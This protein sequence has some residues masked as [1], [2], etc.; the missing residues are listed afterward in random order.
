ME[1]LN[2]RI[3]LA[4]VWVCGTVVLFCVSC[5]T[6]RGRESATR[7]GDGGRLPG[8]VDSR[9]GRFFVWFGVGALAAWG[10]V[11]LM[12]GWS[13]MNSRWVWALFWHGHMW[14]GI[15]ERWVGV[16]SANLGREDFV[17]LSCVGSALGYV[18]AA[19]WRGV[20]LSE[21]TEEDD[22]DWAGRELG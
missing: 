2:Q 10:A 15:G 17:G 9:D 19:A 4:A 13:V 8:A 5:V 3:G 7:N 14:R 20:D 16:G 18:L 12:V 6:C 1:A 11:V 22:V 21:L